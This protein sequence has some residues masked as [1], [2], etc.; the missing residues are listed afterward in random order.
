MKEKL[1]RRGE[2]YVV[3]VNHAISG[4][5]ESTGEDYPHILSCEGHRE[6]HY[7]LNAD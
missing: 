6:V 2:R 7:L 3:I 1:R 4:L 5:M